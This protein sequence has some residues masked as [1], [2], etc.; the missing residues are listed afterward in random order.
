MIAQWKRKRRRIRSSERRKETR[1]S[2]EIYF[3][4]SLCYLV[5]LISYNFPSSLESH[6]WTVCS[7]FNF[8][9]FWLFFAFKLFIFLIYNFLSPPPTVFPAI[10]IISQDYCVLLGRTEGEKIVFFFDE[11]WDENSWNSWWNSFLW[12]LSFPRSFSSFPFRR[13][14]LEWKRIFVIFTAA[15]SF[16]FLHFNNIKTRPKGNNNFQV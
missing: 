10:N 2:M 8:V 7:V 1:K 9:C 16:F 3:I 12:A 6:E 13:L 11:N 4:F 15:I 5:F 14:G